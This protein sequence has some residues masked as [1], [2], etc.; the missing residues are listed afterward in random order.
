MWENLLVVTGSNPLSVLMIFLPNLLL[1]LLFPSTYFCVMRIRN[2][3]KHNYSKLLQISNNR[4]QKNTCAAGNTDVA[5][6]Y[7]KMLLAVW[8]LALRNV[9]SRHRIVERQDLRKNVCLLTCL[10][11]PLKNDHGA[12]TGDVCLATTYQRLFPHRTYGLT[13]SLLKTTQ[14]T[15]LSIVISC[16]RTLPG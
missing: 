3:Y 16:T 5:D 7:M 10:F 2:L 8:Y 13:R 9:G 4:K 14:L 15:L 11:V 6:V 12:I 1:I